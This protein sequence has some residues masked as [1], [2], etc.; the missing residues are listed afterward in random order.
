MIFNKLLLPCWA[1]WL[2]TL[3]AIGIL[4]AAFLIMFPVK[5]WIRTLTSKCHISLWKLYAMKLRKTKIDVVVE[6]YINCKKSGIN[7]SYEEIE[8]HH[9]SGGD[10]IKLSDGL[11][12]AK[13]AKIMLPI[14]MAKA[15]DL[16][17]RNLCESIKAT[18]SPEIIETE[19]VCAIAKDGFEVKAKARITA[20]ALIEK[21]IG[22][23]DEKTISARVGEALMGEI[24]KAFQYTD[25]MHNPEIASK[26]LMSRNLDENTAF[27][28][29]SI[30][31]CEMMLGK[32]I[33]AQTLLEEAEI[34]KKIAQAKAEE[35]KAI[36]QA[37]EQEAKVKAQEAKISLVYAESE[38]PK[39]IAQAFEEGKITVEEYYK[40]E[41]IM[42]D[43]NL[44][45]KL[46]D[47]DKKGN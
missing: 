18:I 17:G 45:K 7:L 35:R 15:I 31:I 41:N 42:A 16:S 5:V 36:A 2:I 19:L 37:S 12:M 38:V 14:D 46:V 9:V 30:N 34:D 27:K 25:F 1:N 44:R 3:A 43:T 23:A 29:V 4:I 20:L 28:I 39:A 6:A 47:S 22:G 11:I 21:L 10:V 13:N 32:N 8:A 40:L 24:G 33:E 26:N